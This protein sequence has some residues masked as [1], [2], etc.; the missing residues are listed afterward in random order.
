MKYIIII[1]ILI[2]SSCSTQSKVVAQKNQI[3]SEPNK[4]IPKVQKKYSENTISDAKNYTK[5]EQTHTLVKNYQRNVVAINVFIEEDGKE[6]IYVASGFLIAK[7]IVVTNNHVIEG[8]VKKIK[9]LQGPKISKINITAKPLLR[10]KKNDIALLK[11]EKE[12]DSFFQLDE[13]K[14]LLGERVILLGYPDTSESQNE[15]EKYIHAFSGIVS[16]LHS[17]KIILD[18]K[19]LRGS[20]GGPV[21]STK[22]G[23]VIGVISEVMLDSEQETVNLPSGKKQNQS[24]EG[25]SVGIAIPIQFVLK[26]KEGL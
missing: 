15:K 16:S 7:N 20:S 13:E 10:D 23:K 6:D 19:V 5:S 26:L 25:E 11:L 22:S 18:A 3:K 2:I 4:N 17:N 1:G 9:V 14:A 8:N 12:M 21:I 24:V